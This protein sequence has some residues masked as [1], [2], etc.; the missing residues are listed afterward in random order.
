VGRATERLPKGPT[1]NSHISTEFTQGSS[2]DSRNNQLGTC[3]VPF[4]EALQTLNPL[5]TL[6]GTLWVAECSR[7]CCCCQDHIPFHPHFVHVVPEDCPTD[8]ITEK[9]ILAIKMPKKSIFKFH[10][11]PKSA[12][13]KRTHYDSIFTPSLC[14]NFLHNTQG[15]K[16]TRLLMRFKLEE[17][18]KGAKENSGSCHA[19]RWSQEGEL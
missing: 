12:K 17:R 18:E 13:M 7:G 11:T 4:S 15:R 8:S 14:L 2:S 10:K 3:N 6:M 16:P 1:L 9:M 19:W 5:P